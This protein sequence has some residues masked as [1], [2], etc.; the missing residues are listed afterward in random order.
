MAVSHTYT[1]H[2]LLTWAKTYIWYF[3]H[4][5]RQGLHTL[6]DARF[7]KL[8]VGPIHFNKLY[9]WL[10]DELDQYNTT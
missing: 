4:M 6:L 2:F 9:S 5:I 7:F 8:N 3:M 10:V 1:D